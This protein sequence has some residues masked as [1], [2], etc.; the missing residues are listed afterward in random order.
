MSLARV[1]ASDARVSV[2]ER[3]AVAAEPARLFIVGDVR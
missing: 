1:R 2:E 3:R